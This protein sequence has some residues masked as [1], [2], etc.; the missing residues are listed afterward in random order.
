MLRRQITVFTFVALFLSGAFAT[1]ITT[2]QTFWSGDQRTSLTIISPDQAKL[3]ADGVIQICRYSRFG[4]SLHLVASSLGSVQALSFEIVPQ[5]LKRSDGTF[6]YDEH[7]LDATIATKPINA[8]R[9]E[10]PYE[11]RTRQITGR[12]IVLMTVNTST[13]EVT[14]ATMEKSTGSP[15]LDNSAISAYRRWRFKPGSTDTKVRR[16]VIFTASGASY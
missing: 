1:D 11:A 2:G 4:N 16:P 9:P 14:D 13:G 12:G 10:Y 15:I 8:P 3:G 6:L 7:H 5:G